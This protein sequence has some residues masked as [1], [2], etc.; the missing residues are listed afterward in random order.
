M[1]HHLEEHVDLP[2]DQRT[3]AF[4]GEMQ[5]NIYEHSGASEME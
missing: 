1:K 5:S 3:L 4:L 2:S